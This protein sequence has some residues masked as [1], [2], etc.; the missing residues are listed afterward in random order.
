M[1]R[2][3]VL[4][5]RSSAGL[6]GAEYVLLGLVPALSGLG[7]GCSLVCLDNHL[8]NDRPLFDRA[9][10]LGVAASTLP[11]RG[12]FDWQTVRALRKM[13][14]GCVD[15]VI[16]VHDYKSAF[17]AWLA[18]GR[19][20]APIVATVHGQFSDTKAVALYQRIE[21]A[22]LR[23]FEHVCVVSAEMLP[24]LEKAGIDRRRISLVA[25][26][27]DTQRFRPDVAP[28]DI[29]AGKNLSN[30][31]RHLFG[32]AM[33]LAS[34]KFPLGLI[35]AY[36][37]CRDPA[38]PSALA[39]AGDGP[40]RPAVEN[41]IRE[42]GLEGEV[43]LLGARNDLECFYP[44]LDTFV[45][46]SLSEGLPLALLE[47]MAA[48]RPIVATS[49]G[50]VP[51][52]LSGLPAALVRPGDVAA[53]GDALRRARAAPPLNKGLRERVEQRYSLNAMAADYRD[54]YHRMRS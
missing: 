14:K 37:A 32:T 15:P 23:R 42:L 20:R 46:P 31:C 40:M 22:L 24:M 11:C 29:A 30:G 43:H 28:L 8:L 18:R 50:E 49:V 1:N 51:T 34:P 10:E 17:Y 39:I 16:H 35:E 13:L 45:L 2:P 47:A 19:M 21:L 3:T 5:L 38:S 33:R 41:R 27:I 7:L 48:S 44:A 12:R 36:A 53:L 26:G 9:R 4:H 25:N 6:Y 52:V 54:V